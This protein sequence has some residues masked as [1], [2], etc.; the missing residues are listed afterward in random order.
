MAF[1]AALI[2]IEK[3]LPWKELANRGIAVLLL[4]L[5]LG[6]ALTPASVPAL[7]IPGSPMAMD[8]MGGMHEGSMDGSSQ[9]MQ[10][11]REGSTDG[12]SQH[13]QG[14]REGSM[15]GSATDDHSMNRESM[16]DR[17]MSGGSMDDENRGDPTP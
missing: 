5:G 8:G 9:H 1:I 11:M 2:A 10:G 17:S 13:M 4:A 6:V 14:M 12:S 3:L 7:T 16:G 15:N